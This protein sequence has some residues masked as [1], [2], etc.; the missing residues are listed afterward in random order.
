MERIKLNI[1]LSGAYSIIECQK[2]EFM[3]D[4]LTKYAKQVGKEITDFYFLYNGDMINLDKTLG[5]IL[6]KEENL[7]DI[8]IIAIEFENN[9]SENTLKQSKEIICPICKEMCLIDFSDYKISLKNCKNNH[10]FSNILFNE[11]N[12]FQKID[13]SKIICNICNDNNKSETSNNK[14]FKCCNCNINICPLCKINHDQT[15]LILDYD[16]KNYYCNKHGERYI[17]FNRNNNENLCDLCEYK[18]N[19]I[20]IYQALKNEKNKMN[21]VKLKIDDLKKEIPNNTSES[22]EV[23][24]N[25]EAYY[26]IKNNLINIYKTRHNNYYI[27]K[28]INNMNNYEENIIKDFNKILNENNIEK[29]EEYISEIYEKMIINNEITLKYIITNNFVKIF[30][31]PFVKRNKNNYKLIINDKTYELVS[32]LKIIN[33]DEKDNSNEKKNEN[34]NEKNDEKE[35]LKIEMKLYDILEIKLKQIK[36]VTDI[37]YMFSEASVVS[38]ENISNWN[39]ENICN[40]G[41]LFS[42]CKYLASLPDISK[43]NTSNVIIMNNIFSKSSSL[44]TLPDISKWNTSNAIDMSGIFNECSSLKSLPD[45]SKWDI[46]NINDISFMFYNCSSLI[47]LPDI[48][49]WN[50]QNIND[51]NSLFCGCSSLTKLP[52]ISKWKTNN[53]YDINSFQLII[54]YIFRIRKNTT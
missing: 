23:I 1:F 29:K 24:D 42:G 53:V 54:I 4:I 28:N 5:N 34:P 49:E 16:I 41:G 27:L 48:S 39:T 21:E 43:W 36:N 14:F 44:K 50:T 52:D 45:I 25:I 3:K 12:D 26:N 18:Q 20:F 22:K 31:E 35:I 13:E 15:H 46:S 38:I 30:G 37:S 6:I 33:I 32:C 8:N 51:M 17:S 11:F 7:N 47:E 10:N 19:I 9:E 2:R 40:M